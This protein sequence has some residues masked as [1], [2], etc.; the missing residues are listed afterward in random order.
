MMNKNIKRLMAFTFFVILGQMN[1]GAS[2][3]DFKVIVLGAGTPPPL[4]QRFG[5]LGVCTGR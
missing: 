2:E 3:S 1:A 4:I 5:G